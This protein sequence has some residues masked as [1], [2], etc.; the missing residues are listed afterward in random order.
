VDVE[1]KAR[2][3]KAGWRVRNERQAKPGKPLHGRDEGR[4]TIIAKVRVWVEQVF[5]N[6]Q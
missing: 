5:A 2:L 4:K 6:L 1:R 3:M